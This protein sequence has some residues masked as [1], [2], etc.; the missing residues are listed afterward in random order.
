MGYGRVS[1]SCVCC[2]AGGPR[3]AGWMVRRRRRACV[4]RRRRGCVLRAAPAGH[5]APAHG[6]LGVL[7]PPLNRAAPAGHRAPAY[8]VGK[9]ALGV[10]TL[11]PQQSC[12]GW[13][14][15]TVTSSPRTCSSQAKATSSSPTSAR[16]FLGGGGGVGG[17]DAAPVAWWRAAAA[18]GRG[19]GSASRAGNDA[20]SRPR[21]LVRLGRR[22]MRD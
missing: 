8:S 2:R 5:S 6:I 19:G 11:T 13:A 22:A 1:L 9:L 20:R 17:G 16:G 12:T 18:R 15:C 7:T 14:S 21:S 4:R 3:G 10:L